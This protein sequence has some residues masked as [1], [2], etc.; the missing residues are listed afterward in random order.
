[1]GV[2]QQ[3]P[4]RDRYVFSRDRLE[5]RLAV[6]MGGRA[7]E[8]LVLDTMTSGAE[9]D[10]R[11]ASRLA[12]RMV[13]SWGMSERFG[14]VAPAGEQEEVFLGQDIAQKREYSDSTARE[15]DQEIRRIVESAYERARSTL[16]SHR[17]GLDRIAES[18][19]EDEEI[20]GERVRQLLG[21]GL[22]EAE[23]SPPV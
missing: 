6:L 11:Q 4:E 17:A 18:L 2:T 5:D 8:E 14:R 23:A 12:R 15:V 21:L 20:S 7:A 16:E 9:D 3:L 1:M 19:L 10:L 13:L 22:Q